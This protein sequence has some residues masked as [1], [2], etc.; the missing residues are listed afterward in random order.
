[1]QVLVRVLNAAVMLVLPMLLGVSLVK[2]F[3]VPWAVVAAGAGVFLLSHL[4]H[5]PFNA[6]LL[7]PALDG[8]GVGA[9]GGVWQQ[10]LYALALGLSAG[11]FEEL[12]RFAV[13]RFGLRRERRWECALMFGAGHGGV[14]AMILGGVALM[15][16]IRVGV[17]DTPAY[18]QSLPPGQY[19]L[20]SSQIDAYWAVPW[21]MALMGA[22]ERVFALC[23]HLS[24]AV[25]VMQVFLRGSGWW[26]AA[27]V[28]WHALLDAVVVF[29]SLQWGIYAAEGLLAVL[30]F[31]SVVWILRL[32]PG[33]MAAV[34]ERAA[35]GKKLVL[36]GEA[37]PAGQAQG[38]G[39]AED[40]DSLRRMAEDSR[41]R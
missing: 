28:L 32:R 12:V 41:Y 17:Y 39:Q 6:W 1:V 3:R 38:A 9:G 36:P 34:V 37:Q 31:L 27:A 2:R 4:L 30:A 16:L 33:T 26:L 25:L 11:L 7:L 29:A 40:E 13:L 22:V 14:E 5:I 24:A 20:V 35:A 19:E 21:P 23:F 15:A 8:L 10:M 18:L